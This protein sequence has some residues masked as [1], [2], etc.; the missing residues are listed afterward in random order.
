M[1]LT[2]VLVTDGAEPRPCTTIRSLSEARVFR[3][4]V[5]QTP[6]VVAGSLS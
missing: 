3:S 4:S 1:P 6:E 5:P 2:A